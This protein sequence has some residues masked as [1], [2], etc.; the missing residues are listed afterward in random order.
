MIAHDFGLDSG[1]DMGLLGVLGRDCA[2][3]LA[4]LPPD[5][6]P[7][8]ITS[9]SWELLSDDEIERRV[10]SLPVHPLG[11]TGKIRASLPGVQSKLLITRHDNQ[12]SSPGAAHPSTHL[13][14]PAIVGLGRSIEN[15]AF[16]MNVAARAG[17]RAAV[18]SVGRFGATS[19]LISQ[20]YDR[21]EDTDGSIGR[22]HQEDAC[23]ALSIVTL[24]PKQK[25]QSF[26][27]PTLVG[28][29]DVL[30]QWGGSTE[31]LLRQV[32]F[33]VLMGN[34]DHHGKNVSFLHEAGG[35]VSLAP[36]Y[37]VMCTTYYDGTD[38]LATVDTELGLHIGDR[39]DIR[40]VTADDFIEE[41]KRWGMRERMARETLAGL[42]ERIPAAIDAAVNDVGG[43]PDAIVARARARARSLR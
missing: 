30:T 26:G 17:L 42:V 29:A 4:V 14:K 37:D 25:Y 38:G 20:R 36:L 34:A 33:S 31:E 10:I 2:G 22:L 43:V 28:I 41:A 18:T 39:T 35:A 9:A 15:E 16:C 1:D 24:H 11:V 8:R 32:A 40:D 7:A 12:W 27:G 6:R 21:Y 13:L 5:E 23:Q 3:A 19:V